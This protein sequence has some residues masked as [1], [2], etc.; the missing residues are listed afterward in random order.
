[1]RRFVLVVAAATF[2][3]SAAMTTLASG[4]TLKHHRG[5]ARARRASATPDQVL[6]WNQELQ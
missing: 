1:M 6:Q 5:R 4:H 3:M 2:A